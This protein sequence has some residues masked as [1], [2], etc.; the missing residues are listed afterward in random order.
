M[1]DIP[2][3]SRVERRQLAARKR[4]LETAQKLFFIESSYE[5]TTISDIAHRADV[6]VGAMYSQFKKKSD[7]LSEL[8]D[9]YI[10]RM[11]VELTNSIDTNK[12]GSEQLVATTGLFS[13]LFFDNGAVLQLLGQLGRKNL[14]DA[15]QLSM[16]MD[17]ANTIINVF[18]SIMK[19]G[20]E[21]QTLIPSEDPYKNA[22]VF[23]HGLEGILSLE[24]NDSQTRHYLSGGYSLS[25]K[26]ESFV[27]LHIIK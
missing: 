2:K 16:L 25:D 12:S 19:R 23:F 7:I 5:D 6:S 14:L 3:P 24:S 10:S 9:V 1:S 21:D 20:V 22:I 8:V 17:S 27:Q 11:I 18:G 15:S 4:I 13:R 26:I